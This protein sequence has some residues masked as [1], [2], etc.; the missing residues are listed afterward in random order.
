[1][2]IGNSLVKRYFLL[3]MF[4]AVV[5]IAIVGILY[6]S[7][8]RGLIDELVNERLSV[9]LTA[10]A[11]RLE[12]F[13]ETRRYQVETL[14][15]HPGM[16][17]MAG[18]SSPDDEVVS[19]LQLESDVPDLYGIFLFANDGSLVR[20]VAGQAASGPPYW[21][22]R[23]FNV[24]GLPVTHANPYD[25]V[26]PVAPSDGLSGWFLIR[27]AI[28]PP[29]ETGRSQG[30]I[31]LHMRLA[32]LTEL[33]G[34][35]SFA[36]IVQPILKTPAGYFSTTGIAVEPSGH[37][38]AGPEV[39]AG[40]QPMLQI[41]RS[42]LL[43]HF[44][45]ARQILLVAAL[46]AAAVV[47][48]LFMSLANRLRVRVGHLVAGADAVAAGR[49]EHRIADDGHD[50]IAAVSRAFNTMAGSLQD[51]LTRLVQSQRLATMGEFAAGIAHEVRNPLSAIKTTVQALARRE[52]EP[53]RLQLL[54]DVEM[55]VTRLTRVVGDLTTFGKP[56]DP[57]PAV[58]S[59]RELLRRLEGLVKAELKAAEVQFSMQGESE[60]RLWVDGDQLIQV[61]LNV[62]LNS[63]QATP[64]GGLITVRVVRDGS[65]HALLEVRD[66][67][68]GVD[69]QTLGRLTD[70]FF[71]TRAKGM[72]LGLSISRQLAQLN[73]WDL[74]FAS[75][76]GQGMAVT[77]RVPL[78]VEEE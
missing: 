15:H 9:Q 72:G 35:P 54:N 59:T 10:T 55:E 52:A 41:D 18:P 61:L 37:L 20:V 60:L 13:F 32:S 24:A 11:K 63:I 48:F 25:V 76:L 17:A 8:S 56:R 73:G 51:T 57:E 21:T 27:H 44:E 16:A 3:S 33:M 68:P 75:T 12:A 66:T 36:G 2:G 40:W 43:G 30:S 53:R 74:S 23:G 77:L 49:L 6:D 5:P 31:A 78:A 7:Y 47:A 39:L 22:E 62:V 42:Q 4:A 67:G 69:A 19:L 45:R 26:G 29:L 1:M 34:A 14:A 38:V 71:T 65:S 58:A 50:E 70:P 64:R 46:A 28:T